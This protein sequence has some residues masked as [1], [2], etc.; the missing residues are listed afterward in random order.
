M[1]TTTHSELGGLLERGAELGVIRAAVE[2]VAAGEGR[3]VVV[4]GAAGIGKTAL[5]E[6]ARVLCAARR[7]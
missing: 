3:A 1:R 7:G 4:E 5:L 2:A 6:A